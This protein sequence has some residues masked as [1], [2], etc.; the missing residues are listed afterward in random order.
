ML[1][2]IG[3]FFTNLFSFFGDFFDFLFESLGNWFADIGEWFVNL[4]NDIGGWFSNLFEGIA[5]I[6]SYINPFDENFLGYKLIELLGDLLEFLFVPS[7]DILG[8]LQ[9]SIND[10]F[11]FVTSIKL[12]IEAL[13]DNLTNDLSGTSSFT[14]DIDSKYYEGEVELFN[15]NWYKPFKP[16]G[17]LMFTGFA[18]ILFLWRVFKALPSIIGGFEGFGRGGAD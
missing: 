14:V 2:G 4:G 8:G 18:Y 13:E 5:N 1:S 15:L 9:Q 12:G 11:G 3:E 16:Y 17:D 6:I 10:K 7:D